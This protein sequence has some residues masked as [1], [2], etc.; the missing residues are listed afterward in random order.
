MKKLFYL[1]LAA[2]TLTLAACGDGNNPE[3]PNGENTGK[4]KLTITDVN[5]TFI[6]VEVVPSDPNMYYHV[7]KMKSAQFLQRPL[8]YAKTTLPT[9]IWPEDLYQSTHSVT[10][11]N[12]DTGTEYAIFVC[13]V[14][15]GYEI[16]GDVEYILVSTD[17]ADVP[18]SEGSLSGKFSVSETKR[19]YFSKGNL[20]YKAS[21]DT[22]RFAENQ[23]N[24]IGTANKNISS[25]YTG[26]I[27]LFGWGATGWNKRYPYSGTGTEA[28]N[29]FGSNSDAALT[30][31]NYDWGYYCQISNGGNKRRLWRTLTDTEWTYLLYDRPNAAQ[32]VTIGQV[33]NVH[34]LIILPD[35]WQKPGEVDFLLFDATVWNANK[36]TEEQWKAMEKAGAVFLPAAGKRTQITIYHLGQIESITDNAIEDCNSKA[37]YWTATSATDDCI[38]QAKHFFFDVNGKNKPSK[39]WSTSRIV[40]YCGLSVR[41][42]Q[43]V[44]QQ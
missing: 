18:G 19:V 41:L 29:N 34:G 23:Y 25:T 27:D 44:K 26:W 2:V 14:G 9:G 17:H 15:E 8:I 36:Y 12:L 21:A 13:E 30:G 43:D 22:W 1:I 7:G 39:E 37:Y 33:N 4:F 31:T 16:I 28:D 32:R 38:N 40:K 20:Q 10:F 42:V 11:N 6:T 5:Q 35:E 3:D 24:Y